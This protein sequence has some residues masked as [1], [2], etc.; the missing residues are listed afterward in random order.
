MLG[1]NH[2][3]QPLEFLS[4]MLLFNVTGCPKA[5]C[6]FIWCVEIV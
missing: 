5:D 4:C 6:Y 2:D 1:E 3:N